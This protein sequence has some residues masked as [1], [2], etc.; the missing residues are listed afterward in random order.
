M[1]AFDL[2]VA[3]PRG[4]TRD[5]SAI[6]PKLRAM[7]QLALELEE[8]AVWNSSCKRDTAACQDRMLVN[9]RSLEVVFLPLPRFSCVAA[10]RFYSKGAQVRVHRMAKLDEAARNKIPVLIKGPDL[11]ASSDKERFRVMDGDMHHFSGHVFL[12]IR[13]LQS[14]RALSLS[15]AGGG[16]EDIAA[17][18]FRGSLTLGTSSPPYKEVKTENICRPLTAQDARECRTVES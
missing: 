11:L 18:G 15:C 3:N 8:F 12:R 13:L 6:A 1:S 9:K 5:G 2:Q 14:A 7:A 16:E 4:I 17:N 10:G